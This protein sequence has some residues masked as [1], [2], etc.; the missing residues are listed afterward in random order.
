MKSYL[1]L[2]IISFCLLS[3]TFA[4]NDNPM[5]TDVAPDLPY[6]QI[7]DYPEEYTATTVA[8]RVIDGLGFRYYWATEGLR[9]EDLN[10]QPNEDART[11]RETLDHIYGMSW[12]ILNATMKKAN[13]ARTGEA[14]LSFEDKRRITLENFKK[15][16]DLLKAS[17]PNDMESFKVIFQRGDRTSEY[18][19]W[20]LLNGPIAD[21]I[22]HVG[23]VVSFRRSSGNPF[24]SSKVSLF[25]G[26]LR[27]QSR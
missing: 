13:E 25:N 2:S 4:Q 19:F 6:Y 24:P 15:A 21:S 1:L 3:D 9:E 12:T 17:Q 27:D 8:A 22:W 7:P 20:N 5:K 18:P 11:T 16:S 23:Q 14:D 26:R 10:F